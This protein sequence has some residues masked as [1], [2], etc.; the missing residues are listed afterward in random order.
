MQAALPCIVCTVGSHA[1]GRPASRPSSRLAASKVPDSGFFAEADPSAQVYP[2]KS[3]VGNGDVTKRGGRWESDFIWNKDW[4]KQLDY[5]DRQRVKAEEEA[6]A[7]KEGRVRNGQ[8]DGPGYL[9]LTSKVDL[10]SMEV[11]LSQQLRA[12][13]KSGG[14]ASSTSPADVSGT[15]AQRR[16]RKFGA[17]PP[18]RV[19][20]KGWQRSGKYGKKFMAVAPTTE[21]DV[22][23]L[24]AKVEAERVR[25]EELKQELQAWCAG[26]TA[27]CLAATFAFYGRE[28]SASY[29]VGAL[30]GLVYLRLLNKSVDGVAGGLG[31]ALGQPRLL[32]PV[33]LVLIFNRYNTNLAEQVGITLQLLPMLLGFFTYKGAV[34][35]KQSLELFADLAAGTS[36]SGQEGG[37]GGASGAGAEVAGAELGAALVDR[38]F[39]KRMLNDV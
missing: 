2:V 19:E 36:G 34:L 4:A 17:D 18:T 11:D 30:G 5:Q 27:A 35:G 26:L 29:G 23:A 39:R 20:Q 15:P 33:A 28:V 8:A 9:S 32:I 3:G 37:D 6:L 12:R 14:S 24:A 22:D 7:V 1:V 21:T 38:A 25:Y 31:G 10:N 16:R 13:K